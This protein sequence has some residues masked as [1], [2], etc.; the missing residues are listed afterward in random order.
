MLFTGNNVTI[1]TCSNAANGQSTLSLQYPVGDN[2]VVISDLLEA[3]ACPLGTA[4]DG[5]S[6]NPYGAIV[7]F[8]VPC[9]WT[10]VSSTTVGQFF[11]LT[12]DCIAGSGA[13]AATPV[14]TVNS[15]ETCVPAPPPPPAVPFC[16]G[17]QAVNTA[18]AT[19]IAN[20]N[21][22]ILDG[23]TTGGP[24]SGASGPFLVG[25]T[26]HIAPA[27]D[28]NNLD[29]PL[30]G[31]PMFNLVDPLGGLLTLVASGT[32]GCGSSLGLAEYTFRM[33]CAVPLGTWQLLRGCADNTSCAATPNITLTAVSQLCPP[34][35][36]PPPLPPLPPAPPP[37]PPSPP[38]PVGR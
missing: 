24:G 37:L 28:P 26:Y 21:P 32:F 34:P 35:L 36:P 9:N 15:Q 8:I 2:R 4:S 33:T 16:G 3:T 12:T 18:N 5:V 1:S 30:V 23:S 31:K 7:N 13:C 22:C 20:S 6:A 14:L 19:L 17:Y 10:G 27:C 25:A 38:L 11:R 29:P